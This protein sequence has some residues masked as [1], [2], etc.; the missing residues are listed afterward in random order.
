MSMLVL[1]VVLLL[2]TVV[3]LFAGCVAYVVHRHPDWNRPLTAAL[4]AVSVMS[5]AIGVIVA[6]SR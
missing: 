4:C 2:V 3:L 6:V 5:T 1:L